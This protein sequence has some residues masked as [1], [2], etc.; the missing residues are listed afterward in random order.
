MAQSMAHDTYAS[1][2]TS[3]GK[4]C[5]ISLNNRLNKRNAMVSLMAPFVTGNMLMQ[6][7]CQKLYVPLTTTVV[8][9]QTPSPKYKEIRKKRK[10]IQKSARGIQTLLQ[11]MC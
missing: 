11:N 6:C 4:N 8:Y 1:T 3:T 5:V 10:K 9:T 2:S 7:M